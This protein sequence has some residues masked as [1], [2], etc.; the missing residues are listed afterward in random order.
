MGDDD[1]GE[2]ADA[3]F[4]TTEAAVGADERPSR[5]PVHHI[6][7]FVIKKSWMLHRFT[8]MYQAI[9]QMHRVGIMMLWKTWYRFIV[10]CQVQ[11]T[12]TVPYH[13]L[14]L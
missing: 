4:A 2:D 14:T 9:E 10:Q 7:S 1:F 11:T 6:K 8:N 12:R 5:N 13:A 3:V